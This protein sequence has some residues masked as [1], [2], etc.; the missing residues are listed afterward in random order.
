MTSISVTC[1]LNFVF[2]V[3]LVFIVKEILN[4]GFTFPF[5]LLGLQLVPTAL[6]FCVSTLTRSSTLVVPFRV[7]M[8]ISTFSIVSNGLSIISMSFNPLYAY[9]VFK[10]LV[11]PFTVVSKAFLYN[12]R[13]STWSKVFMTIMCIGVYLASVRTYE[14][15][16]KLGIGGIIAGLSSAIA[17]TVFHEVRHRVLPE[18]DGGQLQ[19]SV[20]VTE[21]LLAYAI[22]L[23]MDMRT[24]LL[25]INF[26]DKIVQPKILLMITCSALLSY[27]GN[28]TAYEILRKKDSLAFQVLGSVKHC[29]II[30]IDLTRHKIVS[31][32]QIYVGLLLTIASVSLY[33]TQEVWSSPFVELL[34]ST[35]V[36]LCLRI[37]CPSRFVWR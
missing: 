32:A 5:A 11:V 35:R 16:G 25:A 15:E 22:V 14:S 24:P 17:T 18:V 37:R 1:F 7:N 9:Q 6:H 3:C 20:S 4:N 13:I 34:K 2:S 23:T 33:S 31:N 12:E 28:W 21:L 30:A 10:L 29:F 8:L 27:F 36:R 19:R 26:I